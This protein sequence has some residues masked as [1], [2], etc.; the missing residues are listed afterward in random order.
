[1]TT[2]RTDQIKLV[3][4]RVKIDEYPSVIVMNDPN[5][6]F[7]SIR[8]KATSKARTNL[9]HEIEQVLRDER[10]KKTE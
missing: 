2:D 9:F 8:P 7:A 6:Y 5:Q 1:M 3:G 10:F 4:D